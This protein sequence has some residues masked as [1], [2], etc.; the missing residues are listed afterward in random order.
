MDRFVSGRIVLAALLAAPCFAQATDLASR[1]PARLDV[2]TDPIGY[3]WE[4]GDQDLY[5]LSGF[6][7]ELGEPLRVKLG[8]CV[9][10]IGHHDHTALWAV[11][12]PEKP[13]PL[14]SSLSGNGEPIASIWLRF[15]PARVGEL[16]P[17]ATIL[18]P[19][20]DT[21]LPKM[22]AARLARW[23]TIGSWQ[24]NNQPM[25]PT[26]ESLVVDI[27]TGVGKR[28]FFTQDAKA[29]A[30]KQVQ[31]VGAFERRVLPPLRPM[32]EKTALDAF[33]DVWNSFDHEYAMFGLKPKV[34]WNALRDKLR[35]RAAKVQN[36]YELGQVLVD[37]LSPLED[38]HISV[39][40]EPEWLPMP[41]RERPLNANYKAIEKTMGGLKN[42]P[43][44][45]AWGRKDDMG[46]I[47]IFA[48]SKDQL[49]KAFDDVL[50]ELGETTGLILD[51]RFNGG[52]DELL[53]QSVAGR[54]LDHPRLYSVNQYR[55]GPKHSDLG[56][57]L[58][59]VV[60]PRGP[61]R[62]AAPV[63][64]LFGQKTMS[65]AES[66]ALMLAQCPQVTTMG[67]HTAGSS[68]NPREIRTEGAIIVR[69]PRWLDMDP[70][71][72]PIEGV[73]IAPQVKIEAE[74]TEFT[75]ERDPVLDAALAKLR[76]IPPGE[77]KPGKRSE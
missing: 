39:Q 51:L 31:Y 25:V 22:M 11:L 54:F 23:K 13:E 74:E 34:D 17:A 27:D 33:D 24:A 14:A 19:A 56:E 3:D 7:L 2:S 62:Y 43:A 4:C 52:G 61:W 66:F 55:A 63:I 69:L 47:N 38:L 46:Y 9:L 73:G 8:P 15:H 44:G 60:E 48:L 53:A 1:Y 26:R 5:R 72:K 29:A 58:E 49:S 67:D 20:T 12:L 37:L 18:G 16:F 77:K 64:V 65:S 35:P 40:V 57:K 36:S 68:G 41:Q 59:R 42:S 76:E 30:G 71:G 10:A 45:F 75:A 50:E 21:A 70:S 28:R 6:S 32:D